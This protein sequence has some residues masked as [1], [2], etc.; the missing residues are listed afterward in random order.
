MPKSYT[1]QGIL[2]LPLD[3]NDADADTFGRYLGALTAKVL[4]DQEDF[5]GKRPFGN[6]DWMSPLTHTL[7]LNGYIDGELD[8]HGRVEDYSSNQFNAV[9]N[10]VSDFLKAAD[11]STLSLP[12]EPKEYFLVEINE[13]G[14]I[15][16]YIGSGYTKEEAE[17]Q[18]AEE[19]TGPYD[20]G[21]TV[22]H[23]PKVT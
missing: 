12:P 1:P 3:K 8:E 14:H 21:W 6:S 5:S 17:K 22:V 18:L 16:D 2:A 23:I 13:H 19:C 20:E 4:H 9:L 10:S 11:Y 7:I 15:A